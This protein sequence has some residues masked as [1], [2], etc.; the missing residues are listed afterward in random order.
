MP[1]DKPSSVVEYKN[2]FTKR[3]HAFLKEHGSEI[4]APEE[5]KCQSPALV[6]TSDDWPHIKFCRNDGG[7]TFYL[8]LPALP[9]DA[10]DR[11]DLRKFIY[12]ACNRCGFKAPYVRSQKLSRAGKEEIKRGNPDTWHA[13]VKEKQ[14][15]LRKQ[16][17]NVLR[18]QQS[19]LR[20]PDDI[21]VQALAKL[22][23]YY[24]DRGS[25]SKRDPSHAIGYFLLSEARSDTKK[26][27][28]ESAPHDID[29]N[30]LPA[31]EMAGGQLE[32]QL[33]EVL[34]AAELK[35]SPKCRE[36]LRFMCECRDEPLSLRIIAREHHVSAARIGQQLER[37]RAAII[38][39]ANDLGYQ[40]TA[41]YIQGLIHAKAK[42]HIAL[43]R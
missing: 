20:E 18:R 19:D 43:D 12:D 8:K 27:C 15:V 33:P 17:A 6:R 10:T 39:A 32:T 28:H 1:L 24:Q 26:W 13:W 16:A 36:L 25:V 2:E 23:Q 11:T 37:I 35:L 31:K 30:T 7:K 21:V 22:F 40:E 3:L 29:F 41:R 42:D 9:A 14:P 34:A 5:W 4:S 38:D